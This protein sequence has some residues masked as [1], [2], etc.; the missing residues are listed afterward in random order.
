MSFQKLFQSAARKT[1]S[2]ASTMISNNMNVCCQTVD[3][4]S[5]STNNNI[6]YPS[7]LDITEWFDSLFT[8]EFA[9]KILPQKAYEAMKKKGI[10]IKKQPAEIMNFIVATSENHVLTGIKLPSNCKNKMD[11][12]VTGFMEEMKYERI[13]NNGYTIVSYQTEYPLKEKDECQRRIFAH[14]FKIGVL[15]EDNE[16]DELYTFD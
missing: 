14:L 10:P 9:L 4:I 13:D 5:V 16:E 2:T 3:D 1:H 7:K 6:L 12:L 15:E 8:K 11:D